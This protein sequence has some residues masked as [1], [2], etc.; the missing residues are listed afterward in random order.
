MLK[1][2]FISINWIVE[3]QQ[4]KFSIPLLVLATYNAKYMHL[5]GLNLPLIPTIQ[6]LISY[7]TESSFM[8]IW[9]V[10]TTLLAD[11]M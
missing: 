10:E 1:I 9:L 5:G 6:S 2:H 7:Y 4:Y 8:L 3:L 11:I